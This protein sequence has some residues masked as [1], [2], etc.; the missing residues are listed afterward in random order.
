ML[1]PCLA[2]IEFGLFPFDELL[3]GYKISNERSSKFIH[4]IHSP[5]QILRKIVSESFVSESKLKMLMFDRTAGWRQYITC[6]SSSPSSEG[7]SSL[8]LIRFFE[9]SSCERTCRR[10]DFNRSL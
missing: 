4:W 6:F 2:L 8:D 1:F 7:L 5:L 10:S 3:S 9:S